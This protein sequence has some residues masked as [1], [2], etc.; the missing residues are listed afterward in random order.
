MLCKYV[1]YKSE[2]S[3][4]NVHECTFSSSRHNEQCYQMCAKCQDLFHTT[5]HVVVCNRSGKHLEIDKH[6]AL[7]TANFVD[8]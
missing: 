4:P 5:A 7:K 8:N 1:Q 3:E 2:K 6:F